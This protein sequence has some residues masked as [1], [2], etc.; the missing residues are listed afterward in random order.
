MIE[1]NV[2]ASCC[3]RN[4]GRYDTVVVGGGPAGFGAAVAAARRGLKT[5]LIEDSGYVGGVGTKSC[6]PIF[7]GIDVKGVQIISGLCEEFIRRMDELGAASF[8]VNNKFTPPT[9]K[10]IKGAPIKG[11][12]Q[13]KPEYMKL[14]FR[15]MLNEAGVECLFYTRFVDAVVK[16]G[17]VSAILVSCVEG[18]TLI[19]A[20]TFIDCTGDALLCHAADPDSVIKYSDEYSMHKSMFFY[21]GGVNQFDATYCGKL[22]AELYEAGR[23]PGN[24]WAHFGHTVQLNPG[25]V[26]IAV[27]YTTG[28]GVNSADMTR[29]DGVLREDVFRILEFLRKEMPGFENCYILDTPQKIGVRAGQGIIGKES[30]NEQTVYGECDTTIALTTQ[31]YGWHSNKKNEMRSSWGKD[32]IGVGCVPMGALVPTSLK[33]VLAAGRCISTDPKYIEVFRY[34]STCMTLGE[35]AGLM[36]FAAKNRGIDICDV[37]YSELLPLLKENSFIVEV[38]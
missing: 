38:C 6:V 37:E 30:V 32:D 14:V 15:R 31:S 3:F 1:K 19:E 36:S 8:T 24:V 17:R 10:A 11:K 22:Y 2:V 5:L 27:C 13:F 7:T 4:G 23:V 29:M 16:D 12:V 33:N 9:R 21:V 26:N 25:V 34:M 28:D 18:S 35:A 20:D